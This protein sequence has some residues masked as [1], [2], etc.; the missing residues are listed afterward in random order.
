MKVYE[1]SH[2]NFKIFFDSIDEYENFF[3]NGGSNTTPEI[4]ATTTASSLG[5]IMT[6]GTQITTISLAS[7]FYE[8]IDG[9]LDT[10]GEVVTID[11]AGYAHTL[12]TMTYVE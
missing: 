11:V 2:F 10:S 1:I 8:K 12:N 4:T 3:G 6:K 9:T 5:L 7:V